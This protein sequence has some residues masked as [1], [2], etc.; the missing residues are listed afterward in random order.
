MRRCL[1]DGVVRTFVV[2]RTRAPTFYP[3][4]TSAGSPLRLCMFPLFAD[5]ETSSL[6]VC[7]Q[8]NHTPGGTRSLGLKRGTVVRHK[9]YGLCTIG[10]FDRKRQSIS[11][12]D[13]RTNKRLT[14]GA[15]VEAC[16]TLTWVAWRSWLLTEHRKTSGK[17][18]TPP[19]PPRKECLFPPRFERTGFPE[20]EVL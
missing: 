11:L 2:A 15:K 12:H 10:G 6:L 9:K 5:E 14:Q 8:L 16:R 7:L 19:K 13:Y 17:G 1:G 20:A 18:A 3:H 4:N